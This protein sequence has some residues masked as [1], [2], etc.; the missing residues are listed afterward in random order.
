MPTFDPVWTVGR[1]NDAPMLVTLS[2]FIMILNV[3]GPTKAD[4]PLTGTGRSNRER[5]RW[6]HS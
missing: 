3:Y 2:R 4:I 5:Q 1:G 6:A